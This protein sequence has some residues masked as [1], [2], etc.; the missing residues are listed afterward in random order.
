MKR[1]I[2]VRL[3]ILLAGGGAFLDEAAL[4]RPAG[5]FASHAVAASRAFRAA[6]PRATFPRGFGA[7][8]DA[9]RAPFFRHRRLGHGWPGY[10]SAGGWYDP[11]YGSG[12]YNG[13][14]GDNGSLGYGAPYDLPAPTYPES[15]YPT[16]TNT[17]VAKQ[18]I[19]VLPYRPGCDTQTETVP[20]RNGIEHAVRIVRC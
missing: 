19:Y 16:A 17:P 10:G 4:A 15:S 1:R 7:R 14:T 8:R 12:G 6:V 9:F 18:V 3:L 13:Y 11:Y 5:G 20:G 2:A